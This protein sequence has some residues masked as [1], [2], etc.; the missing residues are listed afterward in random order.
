MGRMRCLLAVTLLSAPTGLVAQS[1]PLPDEASTRRP[2]T[3]WGAR[4]DAEIVLD[5]RDDEA[6]WQRATVASGF[7]QFEPELDAAPS[8][9]TDFRVVYTE[10]DL[11]VFVRAYDSAPD[12][13][14]RALTR[15]D[16]MGPA[17]SPSSAWRTIRID[18]RNSCIRTRY[19]AWQSPAVSTGTSKAKSS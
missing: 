2:T 7:R 19:R 18:C 9:P 17:G 5:G 3:A 12:S 6:A 4:T 8:Q 1:P 15:R 13:I 10:D 16:E 11:Y 14:M